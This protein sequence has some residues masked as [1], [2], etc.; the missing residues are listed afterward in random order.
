[1][2]GYNKYLEKFFFIFSVRGHVGMPVQ[3]ERISSWAT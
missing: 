2:L 3:Q 1:M